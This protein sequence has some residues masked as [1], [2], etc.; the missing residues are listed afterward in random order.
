MYGFWFIRM[1]SIVQKKKRG[2]MDDEGILPGKSFVQRLNKF[3][4]TKEEF[5]KALE[6]I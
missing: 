5:I 3:G 2:C 4:V 6:E 1:Y